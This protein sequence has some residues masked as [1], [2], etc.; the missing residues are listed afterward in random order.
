MS[1]DED[2]WK[3]R[4]SKKG[5]FFLYKKT[6]QKYHASSEEVNHYFVIWHDKKTKYG[7]FHDGMYCRYG[8]NTLT[9]LNGDTQ[10]DLWNGQNIDED[11]FNEMLKVRNGT[12]TLPHFSL[13]EI[14]NL[15]W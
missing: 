1:E 10:F 8:V 14:K 2:K 5:P 13:D 11:I 7:S 4:L 12:S 3:K 15:I 9:T 6:F